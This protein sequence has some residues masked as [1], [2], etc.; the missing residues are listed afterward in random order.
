MSNQ[1]PVRPDSELKS[2]QLIQSQLKRL[3]DS[4]FYS[5]QLN[6]LRLWEWEAVRFKMGGSQSHSGWE[7]F[8]RS[9]MYEL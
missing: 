2:F 4:V 7:E 9:H 3:F 1:L 5:F 8:R 6:Q